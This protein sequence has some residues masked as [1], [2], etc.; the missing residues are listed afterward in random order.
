MT[1]TEDESKQEAFARKKKE[2]KTAKQQRHRKNKQQKAQSCK[3]PARDGGNQFY[4][5]KS[6][7]KLGRRRANRRREYK[8][9]LRDL[10]SDAS[11]KAV[12]GDFRKKQDQNRET[13]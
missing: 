9:F 13:F 2:E 7:E 11:K 4:L 12:R 10:A 6:R 3:V 1:K 8:A 5:P